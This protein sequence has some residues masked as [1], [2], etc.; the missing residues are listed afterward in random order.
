M[1]S[2]TVLSVLLAGFLAIIVSAP[3]A[4]ATQEVFVL[5]AQQWNIPRQESTVRQMPAL[6]K[7][8]RAFEAGGPRS[9]LV[10]KYPGGDEGTLWAHEL[11]GWLI[12]L[13]VSSPRI[14]LVPGSAR[15]DQIEIHV[16]T[17]VTKP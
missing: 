2:K 4:L 17:S 15:S 8:L 7:S 13:G 9:K 5:T 3:A 14:E 1:M 16:R 12:S 10:I 11:R 6:Q